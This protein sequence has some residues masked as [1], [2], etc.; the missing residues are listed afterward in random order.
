MNK[1]Y[2]TVLIPIL[3]YPIGDGLGQLI[4]QEFHPY[5]VLAITIAALLF[6]QWEIPLWFKLLD[7]FKIQQGQLKNS[8]N[9][10]I[11]LN[12]NGKLNWLGKTIGAISY[13][14]P[15]WIARHM[16]IL[17]LGTTP[18][19]LINAQSAIS[20]SLILGLKSFIVNL[21]LSFI[22]NYVVQNKLPLNYRFLGSVI[23]TCLFTISYALAYRF[24]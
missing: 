24:L 20:N 3:L 4:S 22:G 2:L 5:R 19:I 17:T 16:F 21:P 18:L 9:F 7:N 10:K 1:K 14:N 12:E 11:L 6:Y 13:F 8:F 15:I 23:L